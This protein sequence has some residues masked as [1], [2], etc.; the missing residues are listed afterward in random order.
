MGI[1]LEYTLTKAHR[2]TESSVKESQTFPFL[3]L[4]PTHARVCLFSFPPSSRL[5]ML[6]FVCPQRN[7]KYP[8]PEMRETTR[9]SDGHER[10]RRLR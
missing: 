3:R 8:W 9:R 10:F 5:C 7:V 2:C 6:C 1:S 4:E